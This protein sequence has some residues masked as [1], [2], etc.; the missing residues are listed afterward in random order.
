MV[1]VFCFCL[2]LLVFLF[3]VCLFFTKRGMG[4]DRRRR[5]FSEVSLGPRSCPLG[6]PAPWVAEGTGRRARW[7]HVLSEGAGCTGLKGHGVLAD[8][9]LMIRR[10][11]PGRSRAALT[12]AAGE[13]EVRCAHTAAG[14]LP[15]DV[16]QESVLGFSLQPVL[17]FP[18]GTGHIVWFLAGC[19]L[20][21]GIASKPAFLWWSSPCREVFLPVAGRG[22]R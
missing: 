8:S 6:V 2:L 5:C 16:R 20:A 15:G 13:V 18:L 21:P 10:A 4:C 9:H 22:G 3:V 12:L 17:T 19:M 11:P 1:F 7:E 14:A